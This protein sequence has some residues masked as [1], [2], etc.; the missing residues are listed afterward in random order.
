MFKLKL[1]QFENFD[2]RLPPQIIFKTDVGSFF[3]TNYQQNGY[4]I[5]LKQGD[6]KIGVII[7]RDKEMKEFKAEFEKLTKKH[8][9]LEK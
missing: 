4:E 3:F 7:M 1:S 5:I 6:R 8:K 2:N 9:G